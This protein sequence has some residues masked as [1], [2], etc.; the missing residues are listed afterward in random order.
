MKSL[1]AARPRHDLR[2]EELR[3]WTGEDFDST[4]ISVDDVNRRLTPLQ[5]HRAKDQ[6][7]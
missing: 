3:E 2:H 6:D 7:A 5:R 4:A 1:V